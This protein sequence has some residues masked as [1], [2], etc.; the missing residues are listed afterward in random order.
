MTFVAAIITHHLTDI[1][2]IFGCTGIG[3]ALG[4]GLGLARISA[5]T[6]LVGI[7]A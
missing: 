5:C 3:C 2:G 4:L 1:F 7:F 6:F